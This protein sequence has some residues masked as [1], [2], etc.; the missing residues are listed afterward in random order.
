MSFD[1]DGKATT[2]IHLYNDAQANA[3]AMQADGK[4]VA[5]GWY[6]NGA[7]YDFVLPGITATVRPDSSFGLNGIITTDVGT[8]R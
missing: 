7:N 2:G 5:A 4:I 8:R 6:Y 3:T 1:G